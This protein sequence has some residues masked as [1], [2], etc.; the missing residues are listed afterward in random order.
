VR[1][2][3]IEDCHDPRVEPYRDLRERDLVSLGRGFIAEGEVVLQK[4]IAAGRYPVASVLLAEKRVERLT[5]LLKQ[6]PPKTPVY[7]VGQEILDNVAGYPLHRGVLAMGAPPTPASAEAL[8]AATGPQAVVVALM[9]V[10][11]H[12][13]IG[14]IFRNAAAFG[15]DAVLLDSCCC[16]PL[17]RKAIRVSV[18]ASLTTPYARLPADMDMVELLRDLDYEP[19]ALSPSGEIDLHRVKRTG[20]TAVLLGSEGPGLPDRVLSRCRTVK[21]AMADGF[22]SL[23]VATTSGIVLHHLTAQAR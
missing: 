5:P 20:R 15:V 23:N 16:D 8:L 12:D 2:I 17:Y 13:N 21:L 9:G 10:G 3:H 7:T 18:G 19:L 11:N 4:M 6:L 1:L 14:G 22:D